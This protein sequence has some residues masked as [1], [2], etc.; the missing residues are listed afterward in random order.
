MEEPK[1]PSR[2]ESLRLIRMPD[3]RPAAGRPERP[4]LPPPPVQPAPR[5]GRKA[6]WI[7]VALVVAPALAG[8][9]AVAYRAT[10][11]AT[12]PARGV[13]PIAVPVETGALPT[14]DGPVATPSSGFSAAVAAPVS[15]VPGPSLSVIDPPRKPVLTGQANPS[16]VNLTLTGTVTASS[17]EGHPWAALNAGDGDVTTRWSSGFAEPQW[18]KV[19]LGERRQLTAVTLVWEHAYA[20]GYRI[21]TS[22]DG[23]TWT[24]IWSTRTGEGG[25]VRVDAT[26]E[27][28]RFVR[29][30]GTKRSNQYGFSLFEM[31]VR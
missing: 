3:V 20:I 16:L 8:G 21:D 1:R 10:A 24:T 11:D 15:R 14:V 9:L 4:P 17:V 2:A 23:R 13:P 25:T 12:I 31:E 5:N 18:L 26:G 19:D 29:M 7:A 22:L 30:V 6:W 27:V 28:A